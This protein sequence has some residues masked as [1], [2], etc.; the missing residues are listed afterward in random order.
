GNFNTVY[1]LRADDTAGTFA[2]RTRRLQDQLTEILE[3]RAFSG[4]QV[5][6]EIRRHRGGGT[7]PII[8]V[9]FNSLVEYTHPSYRAQA[10]PPRGDGTDPG[11]LR[12]AQIEVGA[13]FSQLLML[14]AVFE[15]D[16]GLVFKLQVVEHLFLPG[17]VPALRDAY[18]DLVRRLSADETAWDAPSFLLTPAAQLAAR[19]AA[20]GLVLDHALAQRPD[21]VPGRLWKTGSEGLVDTGLL[22]RWLP[23]GGIEVLG[24]DALDALPPPPSRAPAEGYVPPR[25]ALEEKLAGFCRELLGIERLGIGDDFFTLGGDSF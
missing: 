11:P 5:L 7:A 10:G 2:E 24:R 3:H 6:R 18:M 13:Q 21:W 19:S 17:V 23:D 16:G 22:A 20:E 15:A 12:I 4:F 14:P 1:P 25:D 9:M 8:P